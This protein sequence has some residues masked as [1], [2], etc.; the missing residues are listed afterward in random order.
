MRLK[1]T[2]RFSAN[3]SWILDGWL[4]GICSYNNFD[5]VFFYSTEQDDRTRNFFYNIQD[6]MIRNQ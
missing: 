6:T 3:Y 2:E 1:K 5:N 4:A